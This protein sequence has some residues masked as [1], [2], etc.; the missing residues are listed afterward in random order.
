MLHEIGLLKC[1]QEGEK[2]SFRDEYDNKC[3]SNHMTYG[4]NMIMDK[5]LDS[6]VKQAV[7]T[8]HERMDL[9]G[10]PNKLSYKKLNNIS[11]VIA[12]ADAYDTYTMA[13]NGKEG[14]SPLEALN[15]MYDTSYIKFDTDMLL[16]FIEHMLQNFIQYE[17]LLSDGRKGRIVMG[18]KT[19][20]ARPLVQVAGG[21]VDLSS[22]KDITI[23]EMIV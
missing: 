14:M 19:A 17:V 1:Q 3:C 4:Y 23:V 2:I 10:F 20:P 11:R 15:Y 18:N 9:S 6:K 16:R 13:E 7:I 21:F 5:E 22:N 8:H 12:I